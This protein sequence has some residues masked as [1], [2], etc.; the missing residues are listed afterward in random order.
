M[1]EML[2]KAV[3]SVEKEKLNAF[4]LNSIAD[5]ARSQISFLSKDIRKLQ[6]VKRFDEEY[7][8]DLN[9]LKERRKSFSKLINEIKDCVV[10]NR[11]PSEDLAYRYKQLVDLPLIDLSKYR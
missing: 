7:K 2:K 4:R 6:A 10:N 3:A 8:A 5:M 1:G 9:E 11:P